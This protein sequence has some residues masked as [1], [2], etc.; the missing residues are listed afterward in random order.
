MSGEEAQPGLIKEMIDLSA[1][2]NIVCIAS[3]VNSAGELAQLWQAGVP[4]VQGSYLQMPLSEMD[5]EF[6]DIS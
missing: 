4:Y 1:E 3:G 5:Y 6:L 2:L